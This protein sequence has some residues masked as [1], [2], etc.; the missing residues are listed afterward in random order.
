MTTQPIS[1]A[2]DT[3]LRRTLMANSAFSA[4]ASTA[5]LLAAQP[6]A[7]FIGLPSPVAV[8]V[9]GAISAAYVA[10]LGLILCQRPITRPAALFTILGDGVWAVGSWALLLGGW[11]AFTSGGWW[12][13]A[14]QA[15]L[16]AA[17]AIAQY[18]GLR[19]MEAAAR[20]RA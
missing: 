10:S 13:T 1:L 11:V 9:V 6:L 12:L 4:L 20:G 19:Q 5:C 16:V 14:I 8:Y 7:D 18:V 17:L 2:A 3:F 15:D